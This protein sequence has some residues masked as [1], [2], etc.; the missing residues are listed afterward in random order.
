MF[1][2]VQLSNPDIKESAAFVIFFLRNLIL[3]GNT[4]KLFKG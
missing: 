1:H 2:I 3:E 4:A